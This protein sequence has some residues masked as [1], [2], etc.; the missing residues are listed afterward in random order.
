VVVGLGQSPNDE[1]T[2]NKTDSVFVI[3]ALTKSDN[4]LLSLCMRLVEAKHGRKLLRIGVRAALRNQQVGRNAS[5]RF[6]LI[7]DRFADVIATIGFAFA[8]KIKRA[9]LLVPGKR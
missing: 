3:G 5:S 6:G 4:D 7:A 8:A 1:A 2:A 9:A